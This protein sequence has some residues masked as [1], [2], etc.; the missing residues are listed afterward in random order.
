MLSEALAVR[1]EIYIDKKFKNVE[2]RSMVIS[3]G[4]SM[5]VGII[6]C[7]FIGS[8]LAKTIE[9]I[10]EIENVYLFDHSSERVKELAASLSKAVAVSN[11]GELIDNVELV[12]E[13]AS[14]KAVVEFA[15]DI[16]EK[17]KDLLI[18]SVG[19]LVDES[20]YLKLE[21][22]GQK[23]S[24]KIYLPSGA[25]CA[26]DGLKAGS[27]ASVDEVLLVTTKPPDG[28]E[29]IRYI[30]EQNI[31]LD[32]ITAP[33]TIFEGPAKEAVKHFP[34]N[35]NVA[36]CVSLAG[37]GFEK[38]KVKIIADPAATR[39]IHTLFVRGR[40]GEFKCEVRNV[41]SLTNPKT[42]YLAALSAIA[43][44]EKIVRGGV[45]VGT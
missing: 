22:L 24:C 34:K 8:T 27:I 19:A 7:G 21:K 5:N 30:T 38:T 6:G 40:F 37:I 32:S 35:I 16:L 2:V 17:G 12:V 43:T 26:L 33:L 18:M 45:W 42:S 9:D 15:S 25:I 14:Q 10:D 3:E 31:D 44:L 11:L 28:L 20:L 29:H 1:S 39:N 13:A 23:N 36:A 41:P 4:I